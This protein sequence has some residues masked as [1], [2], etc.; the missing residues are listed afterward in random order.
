[1]SEIG[2]T[3]N[4]IK[5]HPEEA[6]DFDPVK[7]RLIRHQQRVRLGDI[8]LR[9]VAASDANVSDDDMVANVMER[10]LAYRRLALI[11]PNE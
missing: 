10:Y 5:L 11:D 2:A 7:D 4:V 9:H 1:M 3:G 8:L 6:A